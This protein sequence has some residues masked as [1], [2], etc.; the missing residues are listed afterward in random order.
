MQDDK[1][2]AKTY[3]VRQL[4]EAVERRLGQL[5]TAPERRGGFEHQAVRRGNEGVDETSSG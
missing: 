2:K 4:L 5:K 3:Q 1:G